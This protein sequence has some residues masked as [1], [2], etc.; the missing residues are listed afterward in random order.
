MKQN[1]GIKNIIKRVLKNR[2]VNSYIK[3][4]KAKL[5]ILRKKGL[6]KTFPYTKV[7]P[8]VFKYPFRNKAERYYLDFFYS[9]TSIPE[10]DY[11]PATTYLLHLE[12]ALND[13]RFIKSIDNK[14]LYDKVLTEIKTPKSILRKINNFFY[15]QDYTPVKISDSYI[16]EITSSYDRLILKPSVESGSGNNIRLFV[17]VNNSF[18]D[19]SE[20]LNT[21]LLSDFPD[22]VLQEVIIQH[23]FYKQFNPSSNNTLRIL[24]YKSVKDNSIHILHSLLRIGRKGSFMDHDNHGGIVVG[25]TP[26]GQLNSFGCDING[27]KF[28]AYNG[29]NFNEIKGVPFIEDIKTMALTIANQIYYGRLL[30][31]DLTVDYNGNPLLLEI[32]CH[33]NGTTQYQMNNGPLF[34]EFTAEILDYCAIKYSKVQSRI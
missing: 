18:V 26:D 9:V 12:P 1:F 24:T 5:E 14:A 25:I 28:S 27:L 2:T 16:K 11:I 7:T 21:I 31:I 34:K 10:P 30:A 23:D 20:E 8:T 19:G 32:N 4:Q 22:F 6:Y 33:G 13:V 3:I 29:I 15:N 17:K